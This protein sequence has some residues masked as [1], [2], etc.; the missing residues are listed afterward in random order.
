MPHAAKEKHYGHALRALQIELVKLQRRLI[1]ENARVL[2]IVEGRDGAGKD[3]TIKRLTEHMSPRETLV[4]AP[5]KPSDHQQTEW[6]FERFVP[7]LPGGGEFVVFN[8]SWYNRAGVER[9]MGYCT[10]VQLEN[11]FDTVCDFESLLVRSGL[12]IRK[13]YLDISKKEQ[14]KRLDE[15]KIDPLKAWKTSP[16]DE[17]AL[18]NWDAY[19]EARDDMLRKTSHKQAPWHVVQAD[20][21]K[22]ARIGLI[23]DLLDGLDYKDKD[24]KLV[25]PDRRIV[26]AWSEAKSGALSY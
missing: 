24:K 4:F 20:D 3:G 2:V 9:V 17:A 18:K 16:V 12:V 22:K 11:F 1:A 13:Y 15:R 26:F 21:K 14:K 5:T 6:Y 23:S 10:K 19:T 25:K 7:H 8:R